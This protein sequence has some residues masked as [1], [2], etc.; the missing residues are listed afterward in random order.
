M[1]GPFSWYLSDAHA[2]GRELDDWL[3]RAA[4][5]EGSAHSR[6]IIGPHAGYRYCGACGGHA[7]AR[8]HPEKVKRVFILGPSHH[9]RLSGCALSAC[10]KYQTP[11]YDLT[12]DRYF[13]TI[14]LSVT[15]RSP[16]KNWWR[17][18]LKIK[19][20]TSICSSSLHES[21]LHKIVC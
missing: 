3:A 11:F 14:S 12:I 8:I 2:L 18:M 19:E 20:G 13:A 15:L 16:K 7:Y 21:C 9:V 5:A 4:P 17:E 1:F 6:A 10:S